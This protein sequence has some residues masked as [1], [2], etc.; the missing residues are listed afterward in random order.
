MSTTSFLDGLWCCVFPTWSVGFSP[1]WVQCLC[2]Q[3][4]ARLQFG[5]WELG[6]VG[7][8]RVLVHIRIN[9]LLWGDDLQKDEGM[10]T[11]TTFTAADNPL[12]KLKNWFE[13]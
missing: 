12:C 11:V 1:L 3:G 4:G 6:Q 13:N 2:P 7:H 9:D 5:F 8:H 10:K